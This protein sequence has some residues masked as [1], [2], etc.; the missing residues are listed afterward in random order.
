MRQVQ[1]FDCKNN[2]IFAPSMYGKSPTVGA[3]SPR[4]IWLSEIVRVSF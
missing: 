3:G 1:N 4:D 2:K